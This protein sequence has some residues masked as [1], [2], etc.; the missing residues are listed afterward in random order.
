MC[1]QRPDANK[2]DTCQFIRN[3]TEGN[4]DVLERGGERKMKK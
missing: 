3:T 2:G 1:N 4:G